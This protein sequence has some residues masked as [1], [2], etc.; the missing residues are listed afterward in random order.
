MTVSRTGTGSGRV[1]RGRAAGA[2]GRMPTRRARCADRSQEL[3]AVADVDLVA[4]G[5]QLLRLG[6]PAHQGWR[7]RAMSSGSDRVEAT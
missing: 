7:R 1:R 3:T 2:R 6:D 4:R 5:H